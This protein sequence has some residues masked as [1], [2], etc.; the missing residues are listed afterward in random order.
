MNYRISLFNL[1]IH[2]SIKY[3][4]HFRPF[5]P[6]LGKPF[7][8]FFDSIT[9]RRRKCGCCSPDSLRPTS[10]FGS[11]WELYVLDVKTKVFVGKRASYIFPWARDH[12][13]KIVLIVWP[14]IPQMSHKIS[15]QFVCPSP[16]VSNF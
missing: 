12:G 4:H 16:K 6:L 14:E 1:H 3:E 11:I 5:E 8:F 9:H 13:A 15:A 7:S 2:L 10:Y